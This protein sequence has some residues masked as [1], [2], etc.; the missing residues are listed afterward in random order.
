[1]RPYRDRGGGCWPNFSDFRIHAFFCE[2][3]LCI[4]IDFMFA[5][6]HSR[7]FTKMFFVMLFTIFLRKAQDDFNTIYCL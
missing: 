1:M 2:F 3:C 7:Y 5:Y 6:I 4:E